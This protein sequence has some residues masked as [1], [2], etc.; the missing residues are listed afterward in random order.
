MRKFIILLALLGLSSCYVTGTDSYMSIDTNPN[1][2]NYYNPYYY[3]RPYYYSPYYY[4]QRPNTV[5]IY[6]QPRVP[7]MPRRENFEP[8]NNYR[9]E[10]HAPRREFPKKD[11]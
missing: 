3:N 1:R 9:E 2:Y 11:H 4:P 8:R 6:A 10:V 7:Q 5:I